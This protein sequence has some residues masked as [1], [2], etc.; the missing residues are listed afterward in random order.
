MCEAALHASR[1]AALQHEP[2]SSL[3]NAQGQKP[4]LSSATDKR[5]D[6][7]MLH[8]GCIHCPCHAA[9]VACRAPC[10]VCFST[11]ECLRG[12]CKDS[13]NNPGRQALLG[14][15]GT[16]GKALPIIAFLHAS[17]ATC[18]RSG[19]DTLRGWYHPNPFKWHSLRE[20]TNAS[21]QQRIQHAASTLGRAGPQLCKQGRTHMR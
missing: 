11:Q 15:E 6:V 18:R 7:A 17:L 8:Q 5:Q 12:S 4:H 3:S 16:A 10:I 2:R 19:S 9:K 13:S 1:Q 14:W 21:W 20:G